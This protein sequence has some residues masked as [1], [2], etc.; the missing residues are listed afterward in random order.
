M[1][2]VGRAARAAQ[3]ISIVGALALIAAA[4]CA[5]CGGSDSSAAGPGTEATPAADA[6]PV[7]TAPFAAGTTAA[8]LQ[9]GPD[10]CTTT[11]CVLRKRVMVRWVARHTGTIETLWLEFKA[12]VSQPVAC[13]SEPNGY[14]GGDTGIAAIETYRV[15][16]S[17]APDYSRKVAQTQVNPCHVADGGS[18]A[19]EL[20]FKTRR[21]DEFATVIRNID[22]DPLEN[23]FSV[24]FLH[25]EEAV[26]AGAN[27]R[28][29]RS[30]KARDV[31]Y[32]L[33]PRE[34]VTTSSDGGRSWHF[35]NLR[36]LPTYVQRYSDGFRDGQPYLYTTCPCPGAIHGTATMVFPRVPRAW[37]IRQLGAFTAGPGEA[38]VD[39]LVNDTVVRS[40][41][42]AGKGMLRKAIEPITVARG[43]TVMVRTE[44]GEDGLAIQRIDADTAWKHGPVL[45]LGR[46]YRFYYR[47]AQGGGAASE[48]AVTVYPLPM[49]SLGGT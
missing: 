39:L 18:V 41:T 19:V 40:A 4:W 35:R 45:R 37:T 33:D 20:G 11:E 48:A 1:P 34:I 28:N 44:A 46:R 9:F 47:E 29:T 25:D 6:N 49:Y 27:G 14:G 38:R 30:P 43:A 22:D 21:G 32:G 2:E 7:M 26:L 24:N 23:Y 31:F 10:G 36:Y 16:R 5:A 15:R 42:L 13:V 3:R 12:N 17:G 8:N